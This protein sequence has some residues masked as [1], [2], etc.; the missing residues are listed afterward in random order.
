MLFQSCGWC[1]N[2]RK[3]KEQHNLPHALKLVLW[4][5]CPLLT[6]SV[7][8]LQLVR[9]LLPIDRLHGLIP[10][11]TFRFPF[12]WSQGDGS[13]RGL[14]DGYLAMR[15]ADY[16]WSRPFGDA[17]PPL[18]TTFAAGW[19]KPKGGGAT[20]GT[21][22]R[23][24]AGG[25]AK[26]GS[27]AGSVPG[28]GG[29]QPSASAANFTPAQL[30]GNALG[31]VAAPSAPQQM[32]AAPDVTVRVEGDGQAAG[33]IVPVAGA[34]PAGTTNGAH[35][36]TADFVQPS[37]EGARRQGDSESVEAAGAH[38]TEGTT[39]RVSSGGGAAAPWVLR[40]VQLELAP[41]E[42]LGVCGEVG[43]GK[44]TLL[45]ALL[46]EV[47]PLMGAAAPPLEQQGCGERG[48]GDAG[49][50]GE[51]GAEGVWEEGSSQDVSEQDGASGECEALLPRLEEQPQQKRRQQ[52]RHSSK[53]GMTLQ[54]RTPTS[55]TGPGVDHVDAKGARLGM[56]SPPHVP[57]LVG[58]GGP[59][60]R[61]S[62]AYCCQVCYPYFMPGCAS[63]NTFCV[64]LL[65]CGLCMHVC[66]GL[67]RAVVCMP[68]IS[69]PHV[70]RHV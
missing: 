49:I 11:P 45:A 31:A 21:S 40:G 56:P 13:M 57:C 66:Y 15:G 20:A 30:R 54:D 12:V 5:V 41:G 52:K 7:V 33:V 70:A 59:V 1:R 58:G 23:I 65:D 47:Q 35:H 19:A 3:A 26:P 48:G 50:A 39:W 9:A 69:H 24:G 67:P 34:A 37:E 4:R 16:D 63:T 46:G 61:G 32:A 36:S 27:T 53:G 10:C 2:K 42:L 17:Q 44:S 68:L 64:A 18:G 51:A 22:S 14:P 25:G 38:H 62:V 28:I 6:P 43:C 29:A 8:S 55:Q 60:L